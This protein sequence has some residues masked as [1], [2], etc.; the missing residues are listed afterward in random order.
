MWNRFDLGMYLIFILSVVLR[1]V[2]RDENFVYARITYSVT[3]S[4]YYLRFMQTFFAEKNIGPKVIMIR[5]MVGD[6][7]SSLTPITLCLLVSSA[8]I[9]L[10]SF[11]WDIGKSADPV[12]MPH[13]A[14]SDQDLYCLL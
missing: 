6:R 9:S 7:I 14:V 4:M 2:L 5:N 1:Y 11:L 10:A 8:F 3:L 13:Y 12:Q